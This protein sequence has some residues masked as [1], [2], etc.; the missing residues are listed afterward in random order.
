MSCLKSITNSLVM[1]IMIVM[2]LLTSLFIYSN[3]HLKNKIVFQIVQQ[4]ELI[5]NLVFHAVDD[6]LKN[7]HNQETYGHIL[8][9]GDIMGTDSIAI[10]K[11]SGEE[12]FQKQQRNVNSDETVYFNKA[13][14]TGARVDFFD[15]NK[16]TY[17]TF[18]PIITEEQCVSCHKKELGEAL[19]ALW[20]KFSTK[21]NFDLLNTVKYF[22]WVLG[23][24]LLLPIGGFLV[25]RANI[26]DKK[27]LNEQLMKTNENLSKTKHYLQMIL[28][29]SKAIIITTDT[30]ACIVE[31]NRE[32]EKLLEY[33]K[34]DV[35]GKHVKML[36]VDPAQR[37]EMIK[38]RTKLGN[39]AWEVRN[40]EV[41]LKKKSGKIICLN[42]TLSTIVDS[43]DNL[44][45]TVGVGNDVSEQKMLQHKLIQSEKLAGIGTLASGIAHE[46]NNPLAGI[47]G[48]AEV[49]RDAD[50]IEQIKSCARDIIQYTMNAT[51]IVRELS[52]YSR[53]ARRDST[54]TVNMGILMEN[55]LKMAKHSASFVAIKEVLE[56]KNDC[57]MCA[58]E[59]EMQQVFVNLIVN[60]VN[61]MKD[62]GTLTLK[63]FKKG[64]FILCAVSDA[65]H[66]I[67]DE[68]ISQI[69]DPFFTTKD[70]GKGTGLG[71]YVV[72]R[73][74]IKYG[75]SIDCKS[76][77]GEG[78]TFT[79]KFPSYEMTR[80]ETG[81]QQN[82][83]VM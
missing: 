46:I 56:L 63:C 20:L 62:E 55:S 81:E 3:I 5:S 57:L 24:L 70:V 75:G 10:F 34:E 83:M 26:R 6:T 50:E 77:I 38:S 73:I 45:G 66:G 28:D 58:N 44:L 65:G 17:T 29:S 11:L 51:N 43:D 61:A 18:M 1:V 53:S 68:H 2:I 76:K 60:A 41:E 36:Y 35:T 37:H 80:N 74:V 54:S 19:G 52:M 12:A 4:T 82:I 14:N 7:E 72:Y 13:L 16:M 40:W 59:G 49:I 78:T 71:M 64:N 21:N 15:N 27:R 22:I 42:L 31:F 23:F 69:Y 9:Q 32:A 48:M 33:T 39:N 25:A 8:E 67:S 47:L 30:S 79:L